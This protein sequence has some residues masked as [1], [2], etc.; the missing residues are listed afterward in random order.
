MFLAPY[1]PPLEEIPCPEFGA[2]AA[3]AVQ[4]MTV[5]ERSAFEQQ[6]LSKKTGE[7]VDSRVQEF[8]ERM[9]V[10]CCRDA[11]GAPLFTLADV[12]QI[13]QSNPAIVERLVSAARR[14]S[15]MTDEDTVEDDAKNS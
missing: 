12:R 5:R 7:R 8:R 3:V 15:G 2:E 9:L 13:G 1:V 11:S 14:L 10:A 6:F 4:G